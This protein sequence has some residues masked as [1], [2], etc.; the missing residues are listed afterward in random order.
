MCS[1]KETHIRPANTQR[2]IASS[3]GKSESVALFLCTPLVTDVNALCAIEDTDGSAC[4]R[5]AV[6]VAIARH[7]I[8]SVI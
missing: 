8:K 3:I 1:L 2:D 6:A 7:V 4:E 5:Q